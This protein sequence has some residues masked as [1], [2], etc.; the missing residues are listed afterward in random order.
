MY[1][2]KQSIRMAVVE[3]FNSTKNWNIQ[4]FDELY[5]KVEDKVEAN[6]I[7]NKL[8]I[9]DPAVGSGHFLVSALNEI[10]V[11]KSE[12]GVLM[13]EKHK[14]LRDYEIEIINDE[15]IITDE[16]GNIFTY[17][18]KNIES[19]RVQKTLFQEKQT[20]IE[21]CL[22]GVDVNPNSVKICQLRLWIELLKNSYYKDGTNS[23]E[24]ETLPNIDI[25]IKC[26]NSLVSRFTIDADLSKALKSI[27]WDIKAYRGFVN[28]YKNE[29]SREVKRGLQVIIDGIKKDF[30]TVINKNSKEYKRLNELQYEFNLLVAPDIFKEEGADFGNKNFK[31]DNSA[32]IKKLTDDINKRTKEF[33]EIEY[34][35]IY[36]NAF[37]WRF[38]FPEVLNN[39]G[40]FEGFDLVIANPPYIRQEELSSIKSYLQD[41]YKVFT[42]GGDIF[43]YFYELSIGILNTKGILSFINNTF[44]KTTAGKTLREFTSSNLNFKEYIDFTGVTVFDEATTYPIILIGEKS[45]DSEIFKYFKF[46][47]EAFSNKELLYDESK[48][49]NIDQKALNHSAWNFLNNSAQNLLVKL[50]KHKSLREIYGKCYYGVKTALNEAFVTEENLGNSNILKPVYDGKDLKKW[51]APPPFKKIIV[52]E[53]K[54]TKKIFGNIDE[55]TAFEEMQNKFPEIMNHL[56]P[57][58]E[59]ARKR[60]DK[61]DYWWE[62]RN[63]AYYNLFEAPKIIF[64]NLQNTNKF[65]C[66]EKG[67]FLNAPAVFLPTSDK[68]LLAVLNS[69]I[70]WHFLKSICVIR[71]G[72]YIEVKPQYFEQ[73]PVPEISEKDKQPFIILVD[74]ILESKELGLESTEFEKEIDKLVYKL[75]NITSDEKIIIEEA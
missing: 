27:K 3:K 7:I 48:F 56:K 17:N 25:N 44:D 65:A 13:D 74:K 72:G 31:K 8:K 54:S 62:L 4:H 14:T 64:P 36:K 18:P 63:C 9:C 15:L 61:G 69:K 40:D 71:S 51:T 55:E 29:K 10:I 28:D 45:A 66:D 46:S 26:G 38:E 59:K 1:M 37:E 19:N 49:V 73:I 60:Y 21:N 11:I 6:D 20:I 75:Y 33:E 32:R 47:K 22:F 16:N 52:F 12:L 30:K 67:V 43:S 41:R 39:N 2:C 23:S 58:I 50:S 42:S 57:Y 68:Y 24:L 5:N 35:A 53:S 34:N 70:T